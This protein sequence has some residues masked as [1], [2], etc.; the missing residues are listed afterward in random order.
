MRVYKG[1]ITIL[2]LLFVL[3][4]EKSHQLSEDQKDEK[5]TNQ[6]N[7]LQKIIKPADIEEE[8]FQNVIGWYDSKSLLY[9]MNKKSSSEIVRYNIFTGETDTFLSPENPIIQVV[10]NEN[11][12]IFLVHLSPNQYKA[13]LLFVDKKGNEI[14]KWEIAAYEVHVTWNPFKETEAYITVFNDD[15]SHKSY[16]IDTKTQSITNSIV[17]A[18]FVRWVEDDKILYLKWNEEEPELST[19]LYLYDLIKKTEKEIAHDV[20]GFVNSGSFL[21]YLKENKE[22]KGEGQ[23]IFLNQQNFNEISR[24]NVPLI[25][26]YSQWLYPYNT[27]LEDQREFYTF[28]PSKSI[29][30]EITFDL[31][32]VEIH[33]GEIQTIKSKVFNEPMLLSPNGEFMLYGYRFEK[34]IHLKDM[35]IKNIIQ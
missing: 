27:I 32:K 18:P 13:I 1:L 7:H 16:I 10:P 11:R 30:E 12:N 34:L 14:F 35:S 8:F 3:A 20:I 28:F 25:S 22:V 5:G 6:E 2:F 31:V 26:Q 19:S 23:F 29:D 33:S 4:C 9:I 21:I 17:T 24:I 15:W